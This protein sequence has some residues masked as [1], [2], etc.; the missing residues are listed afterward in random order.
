MKTK[1]HQSQRQKRL[2]KSNEDGNFAVSDPK[3]ASKINEDD[4]LALSAPKSAS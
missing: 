3:T 4:N 1:I 2:H